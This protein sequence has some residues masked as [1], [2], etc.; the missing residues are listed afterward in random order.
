MDGD[1]NPQTNKDWSVVLKKCEIL[2]MITEEYRLLTE[3][4]PKKGDYVYDTG[5]KEMG[6]INV[7]RGR[8]AYVKYPS[9]GSKSFDPVFTGDLTLDTKRKTT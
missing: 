5:Q 6:L 4:K 7:V 2:S 8:A 1:T 3:A 9:T